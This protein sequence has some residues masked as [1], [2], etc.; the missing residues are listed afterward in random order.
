MCILAIVS[1]VNTL[2]NTEHQPEHT[3]NL[4]SDWLLSFYENLQR[5]KPLWSMPTNIVELLLL[6]QNIFDSAWDYFFHLVCL[7]WEI[8]FLCN[9]VSFAG[10]SFPFH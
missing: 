10:T 2:L 8:S 5:A 3:N 1:K 7:L 9:L 4:R 6:F